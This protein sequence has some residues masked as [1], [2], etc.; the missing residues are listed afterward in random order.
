MKD[1]DMHKDR[2]DEPYSKLLSKSNDF[3]ELWFIVKKVLIHSHGN[4]RVESGVLGSTKDCL[5]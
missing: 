5:R 4:A 1:F 3:S 2:V